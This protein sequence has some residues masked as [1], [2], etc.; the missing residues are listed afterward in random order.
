M[1]E[2]ES[3]RERERERGIQS[4]VKRNNIGRRDEYSF[5]TLFRYQTALGAVHKIVSCNF[6]QF[7]GEREKILWCKENKH[8]FNQMICV[9][10]GE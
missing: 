2:R 1:I 9:S 3:E 4:E 6:S 8:L 7:S 5:L 10:S